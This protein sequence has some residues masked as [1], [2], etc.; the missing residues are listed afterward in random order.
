[1]KLKPIGVLT[2]FE[3]YL[4]ELIKCLPFH[5]KEYVILEAPESVKDKELFDFGI[6]E[7][8]FKIDERKRPMLDWILWAHDNMKIQKEPFEGATHVEERM[9]NRVVNA[10]TGEIDGSFDLGWK[11]KKIYKEHTSEEYYKEIKEAVE[12]INKISRTTTLEESIDR[13]FD[14]NTRRMFDM[15]E[16][17]PSFFNPKTLKP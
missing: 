15:L 12:N 2:N 14:A 1:M 6:K 4:I 5:F 8:Y 13:M 3:H 9:F 16:R 10:L 17:N 7:C 11:L